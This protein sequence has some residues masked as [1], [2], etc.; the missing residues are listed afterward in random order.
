MKKTLQIG[1]IFVLL[2]LIT[3]KKD[4]KDKSPFG[5]KEGQV[6]GK[7]FLPSDYK[8][9]PNDCQVI[10][11]LSRVEVENNTYVIDTTSSNNTNIL[12][13][14]EK[15]EL[16][17]MR[18]NFSG[19][20]NY[21]ISIQ[22]TAEAMVIATPIL[23]TLSDSGRMQILNSLSSRPAFNSLVS[24]ISQNISKGKTF[25]DTTNSKLVQTFKTLMMDILS[26]A[27]NP[28]TNGNINTK[29]LVADLDL[30]TSDDPVGFYREGKKI[31]FINRGVAAYYTI[32][33]YRNDKKIREMTL[34]GIDFVPT[35]VFDIYKAI[36]AP[37]TTLSQQTFTF[38]DDGQYKIKIRSGRLGAD[39]KSDEWSEAFKVNI[40]HILLSDILPLIN[41]KGAC[42]APILN[43]AKD[44]ISS[45][46]SYNK[47]NSSDISEQSIFIYGLFKGSYDAFSQIIK[48]CLTGSAAEQTN[49]YLIALKS[50][51]NFLD[52][53]GRIGTTLNLGHHLYSLQH[54]KA[55][56]DLC[57]EVK[58]DK[59]SVCKPPADEF[60]YIEV[61][62]LQPRTGW[63]TFQSAGTN[64]KPG[65]VE[66]VRYLEGTFK[67]CGGESTSGTIG[68]LYKIK[69][70]VWFSFDQYDPGCA[71]YPE[72]KDQTYRG[73]I[74]PIKCD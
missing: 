50:Y 33:I 14:N 69:K 40:T 11:Q 31:T 6:S 67:T 13:L 45:S 27:G 3:C 59:V 10:T 54:T 2:T 25:T 51:V 55:A 35:S 18:Y 30:I 65:D 21:D 15:G 36:K 64:A 48:E 8:G 42:V 24:E 72:Y 60:C 26:N 22:S 49:R 43:K 17:L 66:M 74:G 63:V 12:L 44:V 7:I 68:A 46:Y 73:R 41:I 38:E 39:D 28:T 70:G 23:R 34:S 19:Q 16:L 52:L 5:P 32:G 53:A 20:S 4:R 71:E 56:Y 9:N 1:L 57:Y 47:L 58:E 29:T 62:Y 37:D 61:L